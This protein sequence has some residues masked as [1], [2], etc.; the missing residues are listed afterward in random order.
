MAERDRQTGKGLTR[1]EFEAVIGRAAELSAS[2]SGD[3]EGELSETELFRIAGEVGLSGVHV[4]QALDEVRS[5]TAFGGPLDRWFGPQFVRA[6]RVV[7]GNR[8]E[9]SDRLDDFL[10]GTQLLQS[11]RRGNEV[12]LYRPSVDWASQIARAASSQSR[13]YYIASAK[14]VE[15]HLQQLEEG[16][17]RVEIIVD[18]GTRSDSIGSALAFGGI[19]GA[20]SAGFLG[21]AL[22]A[23]APVGIAVGGGVL[24]AGAV[25]C[26]ITYLTGVVAKKKVREV[27]I[28]LEG[29]L[30]TLELGESLE[31]PPAAWR[32]WVKRHFH[33]VARDVMRSDDA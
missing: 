10:V 24:L 21:W 25:T 7:P 4:R 6:A 12:L 8:G 13:K 30:D 3:G 14:S 18:P 11:V 5:D 20:T 32:R 26:G 29:I 27:K 17:S 15:V 33:G 9:L 23:V 28:E 16:R 31:P 1:R 19:G 22:M 2:D